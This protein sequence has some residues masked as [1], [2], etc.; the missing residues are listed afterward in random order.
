MGLE[1]VFLHSILVQFGCR[2]FG[3]S[4]AFNL[5]ARTGGYLHYSLRIGMQMSAGSIILLSMQ[6]HLL[7]KKKCEIASNCVFAINKG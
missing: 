2:E 3:L 1:T 6:S 5:S 7:V 4:A